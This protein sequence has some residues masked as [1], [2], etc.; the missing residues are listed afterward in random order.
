[1]RIRDYIVGITK[2][3]VFKDWELLLPPM[4]LSPFS[5][6]VVFPGLGADNCVWN[7]SLHI[8]VLK[9]LPFVPI[10]CAVPMNTTN[11]SENE[12]TKAPTPIL[13]PKTCS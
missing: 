2:Y 7:C 5:S 13:V 10:S 4:V 12:G 3:K 9:V 6:K 8:T 11:K 1:M